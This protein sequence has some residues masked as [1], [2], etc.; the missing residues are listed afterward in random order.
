[1]YQFVSS[2]VSK[3]FIL[4]QLVCEV[5]PPC[6]VTVDISIVKNG[7]YSSFCYNVTSVTSV[8]VCDFF[9]S[10]QSVFEVIPIHVDVVHVTTNVIVK[11]WNEIFLSQHRILL[12]SVVHAENNSTYV[13]KS[14]EIDC[15]HSTSFD[16]STTADPDPIDVLKSYDEIEGSTLFL[17]SMLKK[18]VAVFVSLL[19]MTF[20]FNFI[21]VFIVCP[22]L[23]CRFSIFIVN[24]ILTFY[25]H[26]YYFIYIRVG[27]KKKMFHEK[28]FIITF[29]VNV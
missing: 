11:H 22:L 7:K 25:R 27:I 2:V 23:T 21:M 12:A 3:S 5:D 16:V 29:K 17:L 6:Y 24:S 26:F 19:L 4:S 15:P 14:H 20:V 13:N 18:N 9:V 8:K 1:M 28:K 10:C